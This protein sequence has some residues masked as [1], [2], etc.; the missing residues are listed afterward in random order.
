MELEM[1]RVLREG[2]EMNV[3]SEKDLGRRGTS[4]EKK[5]LSWGLKNKWLVLQACKMKRFLEKESMV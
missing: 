3:V 4:K 2:R 1:L 5:P